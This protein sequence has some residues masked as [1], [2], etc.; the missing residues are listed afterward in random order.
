M[1]AFINLL[2]KNIANPLTGARASLESHIMAFA[3]EKSRV[4]EQI[5]RMAEYR[6]EVMKS[7]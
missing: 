4:E 2:R 7:D 1:D 3:A 5:I 6:N